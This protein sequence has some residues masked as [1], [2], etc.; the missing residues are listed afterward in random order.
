MTNF[1]SKYV[2]DSKEYLFSYMLNHSENDFNEN[3]LDV[4]K[5]KSL[6]LNERCIILLSIIDVEDM[7]LLGK[8]KNDFQREID[9]ISKLIKI[10]SKT[11]SNG[12]RLDEE[13][14]LYIETMLDGKKKEY[15]IQE[16][17]K[18]IEY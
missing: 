13:K 12:I 3:N 10:T 9:Y 6:S 8:L 5:I 18:D 15:N 16:L 4:D 1:K 7:P 14:D 11:D 2:K 17:V